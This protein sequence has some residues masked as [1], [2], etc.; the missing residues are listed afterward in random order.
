MAIC[1]VPDAAGVLSASATAIGSCVDYI[2]IT[3]A[4]YS[5]QAPQLTPDDVAVLG[6]MVA[7]VWAAAWMF[8]V[9]R[10]SL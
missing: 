6:G 2:L 9:V 3:S 7:S 8:K 10:R 4:E 1:V 5:A